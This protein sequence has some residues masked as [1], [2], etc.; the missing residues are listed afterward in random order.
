MLE[1]GLRRA[2]NFLYTLVTL[3]DKT[4]GKKTKHTNEIHYNHSDIA[5]GSSVDQVPR[6]T[7]VDD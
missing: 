7:V 2:G 4:R 3:D 1:E 5:I 6:T